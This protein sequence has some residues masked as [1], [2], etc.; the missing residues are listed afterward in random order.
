MGKMKSYPSFDAYLRD[1]PAKHRG[2]VR[3]LRDFVGRVEPELT[4]SVKWGN[5]CWL[6][7]AFPVAYT[8]CGPDFVQFGF[9]H[10]SALADPKGLLQGKGRFVRFIVLSS[11]S[12]I[13]EPAFAA[14]LRLAD[15]AASAFH[16][17][18]RAARAKR[19][20][21]RSGSKSPT[22]PKTRSAARRRRD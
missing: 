4:E 12:D 13:D 15:R 3:A 8:Y 9:V 1:Q 17:A 18:R 14:L 22:A 11:A 7:D 2:I 10:G 16:A 5:G 19:T 21:P 6:R 20:K